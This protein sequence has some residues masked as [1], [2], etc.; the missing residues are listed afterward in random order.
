MQRHDAL[1]RQ[2]P[3]ELCRARAPVR[4][5]LGSELRSSGLGCL[6]AVLCFCL[7]R[8]F[9]SF[10]FCCLCCCVVDVLT[11]SICFIVNNLLISGLGAWG[12]GAERAE[13]DLG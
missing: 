12:L 2:P 11:C 6:F 5:D 3:R 13:N 4:E 7:I 9:R 8:C 10:C 1:A